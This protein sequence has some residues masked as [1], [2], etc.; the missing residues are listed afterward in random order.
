MPSSRPY[1]F[2]CLCPYNHF[3]LLIIFSAHTHPV[4]T[5]TRV[6]KY[7][8]TPWVWSRYFA[9]CMVLLCCILYVRTHV[10]DAI[11][12]YYTV[13]CICA[14]THT[15][16]LVFFFFNSFCCNVYSAIWLYYTII[17]YVCTDKAIPKKNKKKRRK[18]PLSGVFHHLT[19]SC[20]S[21]VSLALM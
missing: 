6:R 18:K 10:H 1:F 4:G 12:L 9:T 20:V 5:R 16:D 17:V 14:H 21:S 19:S 2:S 13:L 15:V 8:Y 3:F 7:T 11:V